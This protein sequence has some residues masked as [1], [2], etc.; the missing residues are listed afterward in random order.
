MDCATHSRK[1]SAKIVMHELIKKKDSAP[2]PSGDKPQPKPKSAPKAAAPAIVRKAIAMP[3][4]VL[5]QSVPAGKV[6]FKKDVD[7]VEPEEA[8][9]VYGGMTGMCV[10]GNVGTQPSLMGSHVGVSALRVSGSD[11]K[12]GSS[13]PICKHACFHLRPSLN[14]LV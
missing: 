8:E 11:S 10:C 13:R 3:V 5:K 9:T 14:T 6:S 7:H 1:E 12:L 4:M 2:A